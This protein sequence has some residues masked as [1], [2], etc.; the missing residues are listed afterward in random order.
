MCAASRSCES[1]WRERSTLQSP[2]APPRAT[3]VGGLGGLEPGGGLLPRG[4]DLGRQR[5]VPGL[6][7]GGRL[8]QDTGLGY[9]YGLG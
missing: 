1:L 2:L 9:G 4:V 5:V 7:L 6:G 8:G 3:G